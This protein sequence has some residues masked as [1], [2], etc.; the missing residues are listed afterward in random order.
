VLW[1]CLLLVDWDCRR[2]RLRFTES[3]RRRPYEES[4]QHISFLGRQSAFRRVFVDMLLRIPLFVS[5]E[6]HVS[7][8][9]NLL[10]SM[11]APP[12]THSNS[13]LLDT[14]STPHIASN[15]MRIAYDPSP[16]FISGE[17]ESWHYISPLFL[18]E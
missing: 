14:S 7:P 3:S 6:T 8:K 13:R 2:A 16:S 12:S 4:K 1:L 18:P 15:L 11:T 9:G 5:Q 17:F 10:F